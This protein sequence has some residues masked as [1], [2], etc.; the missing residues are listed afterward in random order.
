LDKWFDD[1]CESKGSRRTFN[2]CYKFP[3]L[4]RERSHL[5]CQL[6]QP[7]VGFKFVRKMNLPW[8]KINPLGLL[9]FKDWEMRVTLHVFWSDKSQCNISR[10]FEFIATPYLGQFNLFC[11]RFNYSPPCSLSGSSTLVSL[12][13]EVINFQSTT[14]PTPNIRTLKPQLKCFGKNLPWK[15]QQ[16]LERNKVNCFSL[17][18]RI[19]LSWRLCCMSSCVSNLYSFQTDKLILV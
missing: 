10:S 3:A 14:F 12:V 9:K 4:I 1:P 18:F 17:N 2:D 8:I 5:E 13:L 15:G 6:H 19:L 16:P 7:S 11:I